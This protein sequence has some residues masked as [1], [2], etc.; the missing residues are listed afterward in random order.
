[1]SL[2][3]I[4]IPF[5]LFQ[6]FLKCAHFSASLYY[7]SA[8]NM[9]PLRFIEHLNCMRAWRNK[10]NV[11]R[12]SIQHINLEGDDPESARPC[13]LH[14]ATKSSG[15][16]KIS[17]SIMPYSAMVCKV[18][19]CEPVGNKGGSLFP[20]VIQALQNKNKN[21]IK[22][23]YTFQV[24]EKFARYGSVDVRPLSTYEALVAVSNHRTARDILL[25][26]ENDDILKV[27][28]YRA[29]KHNKRLRWTVAAAI[30]MFG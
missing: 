30:T 28:K 20:W 14:V 16:R 15:H 5:L 24:A 21:N 27:T 23:D 3:T 4:N 8:T 22:S 18:E 10:L 9:K 12:A 1:M 17:S 2:N 25:A 26:F 13:C 19:K 6:V 7:L 11:G 29:F